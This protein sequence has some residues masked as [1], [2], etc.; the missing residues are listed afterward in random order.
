MIVS[1]RIRFSLDITV[2][3]VITGV[4]KLFSAGAGGRFLEEECVAGEIVRNCQ[5]GKVV[6]VSW[7]VA[8]ELAGRDRGMS[9]EKLCGIMSS[10][11][12]AA[13]AVVVRV[14]DSNDYSERL[15]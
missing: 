5:Y 14:R 15:R 8:E 3:I 13:M 9:S 1:E 4:R 10:A 6:I 11:S 2:L 12:T 7:N